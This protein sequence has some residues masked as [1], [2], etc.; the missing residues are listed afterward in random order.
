MALNWFFEDND[1]DNR[2]ISLRLK[3]PDVKLAGFAA[4]L[5]R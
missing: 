2:K 4:E 1:G 3:E 5:I